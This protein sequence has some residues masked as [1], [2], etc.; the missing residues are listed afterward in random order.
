MGADGGYYY[1]PE[2]LVR[3]KCGADFDLFVQFVGH[4]FGHDV[5]EELLDVAQYERE[6]VKGPH[7]RLPYGTDFHPEIARR[8]F[9]LSD[10]TWF[11]ASDAE[12]WYYF[13]FAEENDRG[14]YWWDDPRTWWKFEDQKFVLPTLEEL[15]RLLK[16][17]ERIGE[18]RSIHS[19]ETWT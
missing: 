19:V 6:Y 18:I 12:V 2:K 16:V 4:A 17:V 13:E 8:D 14:F 9:N 5:R 11:A 10:R 3:D 15:D 7:L 1:I